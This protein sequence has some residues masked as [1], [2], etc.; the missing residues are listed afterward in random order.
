MFLTLLQSQVGPV[1]VLVIPAKRSGG[2]ANANWLRLLVQADLN[3]YRDKSH[4]ALGGIELEEEVA[5]IRPVAKPDN[6]SKVLRKIETN[7]TR[8]IVK[9]S[10]LDMYDEFDTKHNILDIYEEE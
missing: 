6:S 7:L 4:V 8:I 1:P 10:I 2:N 3:T 9:A 5:V